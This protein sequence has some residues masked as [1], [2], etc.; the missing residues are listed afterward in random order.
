MRGNGVVRFIKADRLDS[1]PVVMEVECVERF[2]PHFQRVTRDNRRA[3]IVMGEPRDRALS[4]HSSESPVYAMPYKQPSIR[5]GSGK[6]PKNGHHRV[7]IVEDRPCVKTAEVTDPVSSKRGSYPVEED[8]LSLISGCTVTSS[9]VSVSDGDTSDLKELMN[10]LRRNS[11]A[12][13]PAGI[14]PK[15]S[16]VRVRA[17][18]RRPRFPPDVATDP[19]VRL[20]SHTPDA[21]SHVAGNLYVNSNKNNRAAQDGGYELCKPFPVTN[22]DYSNNTP[23]DTNVAK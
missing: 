7:M 9:G 23:Y 3:N 14:T 2:S 8:I 12:S 13:H 6:R 10:S 11:T 22:D 20:P 4:V 17:E 5:Y 19:V 15:V 1:K 16:S 18:M 21:N